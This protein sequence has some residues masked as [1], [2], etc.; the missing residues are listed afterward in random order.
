[1]DMTNASQAMLLD[2]MLD[3]GQLLLDCGAEISRVEDK[4]TAPKK[5]MFL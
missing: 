2:C 4:L 3:L 1:M 5:P